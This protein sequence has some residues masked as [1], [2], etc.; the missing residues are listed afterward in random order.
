MVNFAL[1]YGANEWGLKHRL[2][3][4]LKEARRIMKAIFEGMPRFVSFRA[5]FENQVLK[6][7]FSVT[8]TGRRRYFKRKEE[9][10]DGSEY[11]KYVGDMTKLAMCYCHYNNPFGDEFM[12]ITQGHDEIGFEVPEEIAKQMVKAGERF[13]KSMPVEVEGNIKDHWSKG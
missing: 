13:V 9:F 7:M 4:T 8:M 5:A 12:L 6:H 3:I 1:F 10:V 2:G 11:L